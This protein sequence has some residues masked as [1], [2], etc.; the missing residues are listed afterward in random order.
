MVQALV[1]HQHISLIVCFSLKQSTDSGP[2][3]KKSVIE[4]PIENSVVKKVLLY[5]G[6][7]NELVKVAIK[8]SI[9]KFADLWH[10]F[11]ANYRL[12]ER[13]KRAIDTIFVVVD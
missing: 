7:C 1:F 4:G 8:L 3:D 2:I 12:V 9:L 11:E 13:G 5:S 6:S 10:A